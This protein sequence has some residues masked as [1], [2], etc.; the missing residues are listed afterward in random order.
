MPAQ[1]EIMPDIKIEIDGKEITTQPGKMLI[2]VADENDIYIP[3]FCYHK[4]LT[5]AANCRMCLVEVEKAPKTLPACATP[6]ND[7]MKVFTQSAKTLESQRAVMEFLLINHPL[8]CPI[9]DQ[10]GQ[11]ELQ[12][13]SMG[14]GKDHSGYNEEKRAVA[15]DNFGP[16]IA[17]EMTRC[18][19]CTRCV[20]FG[21]EIAGVRE[22]GATGRGEH[23]Q[24]STYVEH[25][26][27]HELSGNIIDLCP[28]GALLSKPFLYKARA[29][30]LT[31]HDSISPHDGVG[32]HLS[33][34]TR[35]NEV[36]RVV[37]KENNDINETW[38]SDRDRFSY[39]GLNV[40]RLEKPMIKDDAGEWREVTWPV[41]LNFV[42]N[43]FE[44]IKTAHGANQIGALVS[45][46]STLEEAYLINR[47]FQ[48]LE[49]T[50]IEYRLRKEGDQ[51]LAPPTPGLNMA[52]ADIE[53]QQTIVLIGSHLRND[54]PVLAHRVRKAALKGAKIHVID[55]VRHP[56]AFDLA[57]E[58]IVKPS[59]LVAEI[60]KF[61]GAGLVP[62]QEKGQVQDLPLQSL[63]I[64]GEYAI[65]HPDAATIY[66]LLS[67][68]SEKTNSTLAV[69]PEGANAV[70]CHQILDVQTINVSSLKGYLLHNIEPEFDVANPH[71]LQHD[72][73]SADMVVAV[74]PFVSENL[75]KVAKV[76][77]P[78][79]AFTE[80][81]GTFINLAG[82]QHS[83]TGCVTPKGEARPAWKI[84]RVLGNLLGVK[85][86]DFESSEDVLRV[87]NETLKHA[88]SMKN[89]L[90]DVGASGTR[91]VGS[92][93]DSRRATAGSPYNDS[94][95]SQLEIITF[96]PDCRS[97]H[98]VRR[99][100]AL[101]ERA[102]AKRYN[103]A[104]IHPET[105]QQFAL[106]DGQKIVLK[107]REKQIEC[108]I[109][110]N[111]AVVLGGI[112]IVG[113]T[114]L[115]AQL[116]GNQVNL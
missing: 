6:I 43:A 72:L 38:I 68:F 116:D 67:E 21:K 65:N 79:A 49:S 87:C 54:Q 104:H 92:V 63:I 19:H 96:W 4:K 26:V 46:N 85:D 17:T 45:P 94:N 9:C 95:K 69:L 74:T 3:R 11:C 57:S 89:T 41:A 35:R 66:T 55:S 60:V 80:T 75:K 70:G 86:F 10:G 29:W 36:M 34:H 61:V 111:E 90:A 28:V 84:Y 107:Q 1:E 12:D 53:N 105:A 31:S 114:Q 100:S 51:P 71:K 25:T 56:Y 106:Q 18:I 37:S 14:Y 8:D 23:M 20:R 48:H 2:Q 42:S 103:C 99:A 101:N 47:L 88:T 44:K 77:L 30:E 108:E 113:G 81:S 93:T 110:L 33:I 58:T 24:I 59:Q 52:I 112:L 15:N 82:Q 98:L 64:M 13:Y 27:D 32:S 73:L 39:Q 16:L 102:K 50:Q 97:D 109:A 5:V 83:F 78:C 22:I 62:A 7:G 115:A 76:L 40:D 91:P